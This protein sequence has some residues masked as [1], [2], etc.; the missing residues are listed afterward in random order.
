VR[1]D[2]DGAYRGTTWIGAE[3]PP[4]RG[5]TIGDWARILR[6]AVPLAVTLFGGLAILLLVRL[7]ERIVGGDA[8]PLSP[9]IVQGACRAA[10][11]WIGLALSVEGRPMSGLGGHVANHASWLDI[12]A[13]G[14]CDRVVFVAKAEVARWPGIGWLAKGAGTVFIRRVRSDAGRQA[15]TLAARM[16][17]GDRLVLFAEGT[18]S[19]GLRVLPFKPSLMEAFFRAETGANMQ[20]QPVT[21]AYR[22]PPGAPASFYGWWGDM[23]FAPHLLTVLARREQGG[24]RVVFHP[25]VAVGQ[26]ADRKALAASCEAAVRAGLEADGPSITRE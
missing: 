18:S 26:V 10:V 7:L 20:A 15:E 6:R 25:P 23:G 11:W 19:D 8:R 24:V 17:Q 2:A 22:A 9:W 14:G 13:L 12:F 1:N 5:L 16:R 4:H 21:I 3:P